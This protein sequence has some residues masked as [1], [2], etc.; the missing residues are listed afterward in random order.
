MPLESHARDRKG[1]AQARGIPAATLPAFRPID[2]HFR[3]GRARAP[4][5]S[6]LEVA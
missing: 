4:S 1:P 3:A 2:R 5:R 6:T